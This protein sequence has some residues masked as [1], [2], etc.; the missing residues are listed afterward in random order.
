V[1]V[2]HLPENVGLGRARNAG[3]AAARGDYLLFLDSD[4]WYL[5]GALAA[6]AGHLDATGDP[7]LLFFDHVRTWWWG[8][9]SPSVF[10]ELLASAGT[11]T[12]SLAEEPAYLHLFAVAWNKAYRREFYTGRHL[13]FEPG[14][15]EDAPLAYK[16][17]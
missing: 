5:P 14:L 3:V 11:R 7:D 8:K 9:S 17:M 4:D 2:L 12:F 1:R 6:I 10:G 16:A 15:Y 13:A